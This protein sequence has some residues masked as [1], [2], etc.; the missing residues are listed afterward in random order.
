MKKKTYIFTVITP[1][2]VIFEYGVNSKSSK[3]HIC[4]YAKKKNGR[5]NFWV[6]KNSFEHQVGFTI[7]DE[8]I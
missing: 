1:H 5:L 2:Q 6:K 3:P 8:E 7:Y 4:H